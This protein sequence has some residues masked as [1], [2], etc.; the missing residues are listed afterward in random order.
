MTPESIILKHIGTIK[1]MRVPMAKF[2]VQKIMKDL[3]DEG[4]VISEARQSPAGA[5]CD[6]AFPAARS[7][8]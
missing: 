3:A 4:Y 2:I 1:G 7:G 8:Q 6:P 5:S